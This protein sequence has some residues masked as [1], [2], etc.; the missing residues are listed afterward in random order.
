MY[1]W[2]IL[3]KFLL[4]RNYKNT[5]GIHFWHWMFFD[6]GT[7]CCLH[8]LSNNLELV[9]PILSFNKAANIGGYL[10]A[11]RKWSL[12][13]AFRCGYLSML[14]PRLFQVLVNI[15][16]HF[17]L[18]SSIFVAPRKGI[19]SFSFHVVKVYNSQTIQVGRFESQAFE[20]LV[21][22]ELP[23]E[24]SGNPLF[25]VPHV[26][27]P[28]VRWGWQSVGEEENRMWDRGDFWSAEPSSLP[29]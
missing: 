11:W 13:R 5:F 21:N 25:P 16:N 20:S 28:K 4:I 18:A 10:K 7:L 9:G 27:A 2:N 17:D 26:W 8:C 14:F 3:P 24:P 29:W 1:N 19:Y 22:E 12:L 6:L 15:G 23:S